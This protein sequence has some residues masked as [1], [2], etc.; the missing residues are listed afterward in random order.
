MQ[1]LRWIDARAMQG[2]LINDLHR[3]WL[4]W[5]AV[6]AGTRLLRMHPMVSHDGPISIA[7][8]VSRADW[9]RLL[10]AA[11][12]EAEIRWCLPFRWAVSRG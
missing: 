10:A 3:H 12:I 6:A 1:F 2:W 9:I 7:R 5:V 4:P 8:A 11:G